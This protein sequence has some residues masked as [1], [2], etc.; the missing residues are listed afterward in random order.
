VAGPIGYAHVKREELLYSL[1]KASRI[2][3]V[4]CTEKSSIDSRHF[5]NFASAS[6]APSC[7]KP[8]QFHVRN[9]LKWLK[10][11][12]KDWE[13]S[14]YILIS[15]NFLRLSRAYLIKFKILDTMQLV[16]SFRHLV[17]R[18]EIWIPDSLHG[19]SKQR[20]KIRRIQS[21]QNIA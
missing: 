18:A 1:V 5:T 15:I 13:T 17:Q 7:H 2:K 21:T 8:F 6:S 14:F 3:N 19:A 4:Q 20:M 9:F 12:I 11:G 10:S 16:S